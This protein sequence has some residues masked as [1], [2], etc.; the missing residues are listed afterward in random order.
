MCDDRMSKSWTGRG[1]LQRAISTPPTSRPIFRWSNPSVSYA[2]A[3]CDAALPAQSSYGSKFMSTRQT[4]IE[5]NA[6]VH[7]PA[8]ADLV[9]ISLMQDATRVAILD[10][11]GVLDSPREVDFDDIAE[12]AAGIC[13][14]PITV[15]NFIGEGR[16][17]FK[18]EVGLGVRETPLETSFCARAILESD[19]LLVPDASLDPR[20]ACNPLV[21]Q[22]TPSSL[23]RGCP[24]QDERGYPNRDSLRPRL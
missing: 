22:G 10:G 5:I 17:F 15:V 1:W 19:L 13:Q 6:G 24:H 8:K 20:F 23:L 11:Y 16:Q 12:L 9:T 18:A 21:T 14:T 7:S 4:L 3:D 2:E